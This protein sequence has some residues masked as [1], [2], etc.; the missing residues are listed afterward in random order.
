MKS[1]CIIEMNVVANAK[2][3]PELLENGRYRLIWLNPGGSYVA[4]T[5][6]RG[7]EIHEMMGKVVALETARR[8]AQDAKAAA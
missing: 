7:D 2:T 8:Q 4:L 1:L 3:V 5:F 6:E